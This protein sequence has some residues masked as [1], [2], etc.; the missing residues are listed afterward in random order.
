[1]VVCIVVVPLFIVG[2]VAV[3]F[4]VVRPVIVA[5]VLVHACRIAVPVRVAVFVIV[6]FVVVVHVRC[7]LVPCQGRLPGIL[8]G[9]F[10]GI[11]LDGRRGGRSSRNHGLVRPVLRCRFFTQWFILTPGVCFCGRGEFRGQRWNV[12]AGLVC[13]LR[14]GIV[15][16]GVEGLLPFAEFLAGQRPSCPRVQRAGRVVN[17]GRAH[18]CL[19]LSEDRSVSP[20]VEGTVSGPLPPMSTEGGGAVT[21]EPTSAP[22]A[23]CMSMA[24]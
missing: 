24:C 7:V 22:L 14:N 13:L 21:R 2:P 20:G 11:V 18:W 8:R 16:S 15:A 6:G 9:G 1:M 12:V 4:L 19:P 17:V 5:I 10:V 23:F 3:P